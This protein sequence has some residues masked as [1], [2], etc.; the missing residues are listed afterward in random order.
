V[1]NTPLFDSN[2]SGIGEGMTRKETLLVKKKQKEISLLT[3]NCTLGNPVCLSYASPPIWKLY[4]HSDI[5]SKLYKPTFYNSHLSH[6]MSYGG[7]ATLQVFCL[8]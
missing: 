6:N 2:I 4:L 7:A 8:P 5:I 3:L 1:G